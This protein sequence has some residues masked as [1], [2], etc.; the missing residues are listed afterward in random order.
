LGKLDV[1]YGKIHTRVE[2]I[3]YEEF[4]G[5]ITRYSKLHHKELKDTTDILELALWKAMMSEWMPAKSHDDAVASW[6]ERRVNSLRWSFHMF[7]HSCN[8]FMPNLKSKVYEIIFLIYFLSYQKIIH[9][10]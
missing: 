3:H 5:L 10:C 4:R 9:L 1:L 7:Y 2:Q 6:I 8:A